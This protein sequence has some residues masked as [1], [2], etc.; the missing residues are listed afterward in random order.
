MQGLGLRVQGLGFRVLVFWASGAGPRVHMGQ[1][2][3]CPFEGFLQ[4]VCIL[5]LNPKP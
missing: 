4:G 5:A 1:K 2:A 3:Y